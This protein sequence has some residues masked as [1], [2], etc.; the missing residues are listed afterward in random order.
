[1]QKLQVKFPS[2]NPGAIESI[3][4]PFF[5]ELPAILYLANL[6]QYS[7]GK[8]VKDAEGNRGF[9]FDESKVLFQGTLILTHNA[10]HG[11]TLKVYAGH[12]FTE[13]KEVVQ[14]SDRVSFFEVNTRIESKYYEHGKGWSLQESCDFKFSMFSGPAS[15][16]S[17]TAQCTKYA[18]RIINQLEGALIA[19][20]FKEPK[21]AECFR[22]YW[23]KD[24]FP[25]GDYR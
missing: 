2:V 4:T 3:K 5:I 10:Y 6:K 7:Q 16:F 18:A 23:E 13:R 19:Y 11:Y 25:E 20:N 21:D 22:E 8:E 14:F 9:L 1:M 17:M 15:L 12:A 24:V